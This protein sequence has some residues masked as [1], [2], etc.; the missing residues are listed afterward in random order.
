MKYIRGDDVTIFYL[1]KLEDLFNYLESINI[2]DNVVYQKIV[3][4]LP[5]D[6]LAKLRLVPDN[7]LG[8]RLAHLEAIVHAVLNRSPIAG[9]VNYAVISIEGSDPRIPFDCDLVIQCTHTEETIFI[10][11][12]ASQDWSIIEKKKII[13]NQ[14]ILI[15]KFATAR[16]AVQGFIPRHFTIDIQA[17][18]SSNE[19]GTEGLKF[20]DILS[21]TDIKTRT[22]FIQDCKTVYTDATIDIANME[23]HDAPGDYKETEL[24]DSLLHDALNL[25]STQDDPK[26]LDFIKKAYLEAPGYHPYY[27]GLVKIFNGSNKF[28]SVVPIEAASVKESRDLV[29]TLAGLT[30]DWLAK[31]LHASS[32]TEYVVAIDEAND[33]TIL[34]DFPN[35]DKKGVLD[36]SSPYKVVVKRKKGHVF[37]IKFNKANMD[38]K[39]KR[40]LTDEK[41]KKEK[42]YI[43]TNETPNSV[44]V[45]DYVADAISR[46]ASD[47]NYFQSLCLSNPRD[48]VWKKILTISALSSNDLDNFGR[49]TTS[50]LDGCVSALEQTYTGACISHFY[51]INKSILAS[52][53]VSP[54]D[55]DYYVGVN[56]SYDSVSI[57]KM[58]STLDS[59][60]RCAYSVVYKHERLPSKIHTRL[61]SKSTG[62]VSRTD[63]YSSDPNQLSYALRLPFVI[64]S[65]ATWEI[66][67]NMKSGSI[68]NGVSSQ[69]L[70]DST[71]VALINRD[72]FAQV[73]E[74][75]RYFY[76][77]SIGYG[78]SAADII[79][80]T[81]F[82]TCRHH[83]EVIYILRAYKLAA[84]LS[85]IS[86][87]GALPKI[88][89][90]PTADL[91][92]AFPHSNFPS[93]SFSQTISSMYIC[94]IYNKFRAFHEIS[95]AICFNEIIEER[96][97]YETRI[98]EDSN[99]V[100]GLSPNLVQA[101]RKGKSSL[102]NY[103]SSSNFIQE[104]IQFSKSLALIK[105]NRYSGSAI[106]MIGASALH[107]VV[108][109][110]IIDSIYDK[111][112]RG[113]IEACTMRGSMDSGESKESHQGIRAASTI[114]EELIRKSKMEPKNVNGSVLGSVYLMDHLAKEKPTFSILSCVVDQF[115]DGSV[116]YRYR[117]VQKDQKGH[118]EI[119]VLNFN[120]RIG[121]LF[122]ETISRE[123]FSVVSETEIAN[124]PNKD[125]IIE[126]LLS[127]TF[128]KD[129][130]AAGTHCYDN[131]DQKRWGPNH[132]VN[133]FSYVLFPMLQNDPG[134]FRLVT[135]VF[136]LVLDKRAKYPESLIDLVIKKNIKHSNSLAISKFLSYASEK[137]SNKV[138]EESMS[139]G[140]CQ[141]I[142]Q[143]T[144]SGIHAIK[145]KAHA[146][147]VQEIYP[148]V[149]M[150]FLTTSDDAEGVSHIPS[151][152]DKVKVVKFIHCTGL[153]MGNLFNI[154]RSNPKS[155]YNFHIAELNSIFFRKGIMATPSLKQRIAK[156]DV[157]MGVNHIEDYL[158][159]LASASNYLA[160][161]GSYM[162]SV[163]VSILNLVLHTEQWLRWEFVK[164]D[165]YYKPVEFGGF[166]VI[167]PLSTIL[168]GGIA[169]FYQRVSTVLRPEAYSR[170]VTNSL[171]CPPE[172]VSLEEFSRSGN[173][174][175]KKSYKARDLSIFKGAGP[176]GIFQMVKTDRKLSQ[177]ERRH[178][179]SNWIIP[180]SFATL[181]RDSPIASDFIFSIF[182]STSVSTLDTNLGVNSFFIRMAEPWASFTRPC[183]RMS[184]NSPF[185]KSFKLE[186]LLI[187][188]KELADKMKYMTMIESA[189]ELELSSR[190]C[191][192]HIEFEVMEAQLTVRLSDAASIKDFLSLQEA[193]TFKLSRV[194]PSIQRVTLRGYSASDSDTYMLS[195]IKSM[196]GPKS[197]GLINEYKRTTTTYDSI[198]I[199]EPAEPM[200]LLTA[201]V[202][203]DNAIALYNKFIRR[204]TKMILPNR[205][206]DLK[207]LCVDII[208][209]KFCE[210]LGMV[211]EGDLELNPERSKPYAYSKWYQELITVSQDAETRLA[212][213]ILKHNYIDLA[214][215]G[216]A[217]NRTIISKADTFEI[218]SS[219]APQKT[220]LVD[221]KSKDSFV[222]T[223]RTWLGAKVRFLLSRDCTKSL[224]AG[225]LNFAHDYYVGNNRFYRFAK[226]KYFEAIAGTAKGLHVIQTT[227]KNSNSKL[228]TTYRHMLIF[229]EDISGRKVTITVRDEYKN[230][231]WIKSL[232]SSLENIDRVKE[233]HWYVVNNVTKNHNNFYRKSEKETDFLFISHISPG[234]EF[235]L[236]FSDDSFCIML[237]CKNFSLPV[238]YLNPDV[239]ENLD[240]G[241]DLLHTDLVI[242]TKAYS[243]LRD[244]TSNFSK[245][246]INSWDELK[247]ALDFILVAS[248]TDTP[249][250]IIN[251]VLF[252][253]LATNITTIQLDILRT[254]MIKNQKIGIGFSSSRFNQYLLNLGNRR[255]HKHSYLCKTISGTRADM[256][257]EDWD[258]QSAEE[259]IL[260]AGKSN[261]H[262]FTD[263]ESDDDYEQPEHVRSATASSSKVNAKQ[264]SS[265]E[266]YPISEEAAVPTSSPWADEVIENIYDAEDN[267]QEDVQTAQDFNL[268]SDTE[269]DDE[270][271]ADAHELQKTNTN[272][273]LEVSGGI[274]EVTISKPGS[275]SS[276]INYQQKMSELIT[277]LTS[278]MS[279]QDLMNF[280]DDGESESGSG[281][282]AAL[283]G[284]TM[285]RIF[286]SAV[287]LT[288][289]KIK[290]DKDK[291]LKSERTG[292]T[293]SANLESSRAMV[294]FI[295]KWVKT[296][297]SSMEFDQDGIISDNVSSVTGM[298]LLMDKFG[299]LEMSNPLEKFYGLDSMRIPVPLS[300]LAVVGE[301]YN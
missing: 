298:Y 46:Y 165:H 215:V 34:K 261:P 73:S 101:I 181:R 138:F 18:F 111:V 47:S 254:F 196:A 179:I 257:S 161:G 277:N 211:L 191:F 94:N 45:E 299:V 154:V 100:S 14:N 117:I 71:M 266:L 121:A 89:P 83:W 144:S 206:D 24:T 158:S 67:N 102:V 149:T 247:S 197:R 177:F 230:E 29:A 219:S 239:I 174:R 235:E 273:N 21:T 258:V 216:I 17:I 44:T 205:V 147:V 284:E 48:S 5:S 234:T 213:A 159:C 91:K 62:S 28:K 68:A 224:I 63:F 263:F 172:E 201:V 182:R 50:M 125:K 168:S 103:I 166:P 97:I 292:H 142:F 41:I 152:F 16:G 183:L 203:A 252:K 189:F 145:T 220:I 150:Q 58:S 256:D 178:G 229:N 87:K 52:L 137:I 1:N 82:L 75:V 76:M 223:L 33:I 110:A 115:L 251:R 153:R 32:L 249:D 293:V 225:R 184:E 253:F 98:R 236:E 7:S 295:K 269:P 176:L 60:S 156:I 282:D 287:N 222:S 244:I 124:N 210:N 157:G 13:I 37:T 36:A 20:M 84:A 283:F 26:S 274:P 214:L 289:D 88:N 126:D 162:G 49:S 74:Q 35:S 127:E 301:I 228:T 195:M 90:D 78:G 131:S 212:N 248:T 288:Y 122:V 38:S 285:E 267:I 120:F 134:L 300:A 279:L 232:L 290:D 9:V 164:S 61:S 272:T 85:T 242:A 140:M 268:W 64:V 6:L 27:K 12:T 66:E 69:I 95:E 297:G 180:E 23:N 188:H 264:S 112:N 77:S 238:T 53:K 81:T 255:D 8:P 237:A 22:K 169:N 141:G 226:S 186:T 151:G 56:G 25:I 39:Q 262:E 208:T 119:S 209:N 193:E 113:P 170:L 276:P 54:G 185:V 291:G 143:Q 286:S 270:T 55:S 296:V 107:A 80:K 200:P 160:S 11:F 265:P 72:Q 129:K 281:N 86:T 207:G 57:V 65:L 4:Y 243:K 199:Q 271:Y 250:F 40:Y 132:N 260:L 192:K 109:N 280:D 114:L 175:V 202:M 43:K 246:R 187:S 42:N 51:E 136:D 108:P 294:E 198:N 70:F 104:E 79:D 167:E 278:G 173:E 218:T 93:N 106:F 233:N 123:L 31:A 227:I 116:V 105:S 194:S 275:P 155:A 259:E 2:V 96:S 139:A 130:V 171:L 135:R 59:F 241:Y 190:R 3:E 92:V 163:I 240:M 217:S 133:F 128:K 221:S 99:A 204:D 10:D 148:T 231:Y 30:D 245:E 118:R 15:N 146:R 19:P